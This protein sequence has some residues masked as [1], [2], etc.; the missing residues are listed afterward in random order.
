[1]SK[2]HDVFMKTAFLFAE[3]SKCVSHHV[4]AVIVKDERI[5]S[6]G[7]N[8]SPPGLPNCCEVFDKDNFDRAEHSPWSRDNEIHAEMNSLMYATKTNI[9]TEGA[10]IYVT[11]SPCNDCLK[12]LTASG[13]KNVYYLY[14]YDSSQPNPALLKRINVKVVPGA[15]EIK[16]W[17]E[18]NDLLYVP[19]QRQEKTPGEPLRVD[20]SKHVD[21]IL[22]F[23]YN[24]GWNDEK[25]GKR[26]P[27]TNFDPG[28]NEAY[29]LGIDDYY[30]HN[31]GIPLPFDRDETLR[32][33]YEKYQSSD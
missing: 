33:I 10:D 13:I 28:I 31:D 23:Y 14:P 7:Y 18:R 17:V 19:K 1:M 11:I 9:E 4:G 25:D 22:I 29:T 32:R 30:F 2:M 16:R 3:K 21:D 5:I 6:V 26:T 15:S 20:W 27:F 8:G 12:N 24:L